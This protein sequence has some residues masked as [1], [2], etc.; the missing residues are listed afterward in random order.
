MIGGHLFSLPRIGVYGVQK[1]VFFC[2]AFRLKPKTRH[3]RQEASVPFVQ[4]SWAQ[5]G[6]SLF[7]RGVSVA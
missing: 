5:L 2:L 4:Q 1:S 3:R 7:A 6:R